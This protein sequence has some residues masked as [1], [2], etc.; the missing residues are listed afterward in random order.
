MGGGGDALRRSA[1]R[2]PAPTHHCFAGGAGLAS[3]VSSA[4]CVSIEFPPGGMG[5]APCPGPPPPPPAPPLPR[6][7]AYHYCIKH[8]GTSA[9]LWRISST[10]ALTFGPGLTEETKGTGG[11]CFLAP[12]GQVAGFPQ[13]RQ[14]GSREGRGPYEVRGPG[15][16][17]SC[18]TGRCCCPRCLFSEI[19]VKI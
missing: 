10:S 8:T 4:S 18:F 14:G 1:S 6:V 19:P 11:M 15:A 13:G 7:K 12:E 17:P 5:A 3:F 9:S 16:P 2:F